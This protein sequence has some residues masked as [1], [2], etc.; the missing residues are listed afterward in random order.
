MRLGIVDRIVPAR[1]GPGPSPDVSG[2]C[3]GSGPPPRW[4]RPVRDGRLHAHRPP[5]TA[6]PQRAG[7]SSRADTADIRR[8]R[9]GRAAS[10][11]GGRRSRPRRPR[12]GYTY[13]DADRGR[14][15]GD[16]RDLRRPGAVRPAQRQRG[17]RG[18]GGTGPGGPGR[19][20]RR[21]QAAAGRVQ[22]RVQA[23]RRRGRVRAGGPRD[24]P[25]APRPGQ[26]GD[27]PLGPGQDRGLGPR[28]ARARR[29]GLQRPAEPAA[30]GPERPAHR[31]RGRLRACGAPP[32]A[33]ASTS[34]AA[35]SARTPPATS[36]TPRACP[37]PR[38]TWRSCWP[39]PAPG[40]RWS[41]TST[42]SGSSWTWPA[43][44]R[45]ARGPRC[46][47]RTVRPTSTSPGWARDFIAVLG[48]PGP[49]AGAAQRAPAA[50]MGATQAG[51]S[52]QPAWRL[53]RGGGTLAGPNIYAGIEIL[54]SCRNWCQ[55][56]RYREAEEE[57][58][59]HARGR[60]PA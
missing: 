35:R 6:T 57:T 51:V 5:C 21:A 2:A 53:R 20:R 46:P 34:P 17:S 14:I 12:R 24:Q 23:V 55:E 48:P 58:P 8:L 16:R 28:R 42:P 40:S 1:S 45:L 33:A 22:R 10:P 25:A 9:P 39:T 49:A 4:P 26:P 13:P 31:G 29:G 56:R 37:P 38:P 11:A 52:A 41:S 36:S 60:R 19:G 44:R 18:G 3:A 59:G 7:P 43:G 47:A 27:R 32:S 30:A 50:L 54:H 15:R